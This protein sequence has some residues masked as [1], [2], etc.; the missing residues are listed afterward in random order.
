ME[1]SPL[2]VKRSVCLA[3]VGTIFASLNRWENYG[4][5]FPFLEDISKDIASSE[6]GVHSVQHSENPG[7]CSCVWRLCSFIRLEFHEI[8]PYKHEQGH[9][10]FDDDPDCFFLNVPLVCSGGL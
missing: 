3:I 1:E 9:L 5:L 10:W 2:Q 6:C 8:D 7:H 4:R